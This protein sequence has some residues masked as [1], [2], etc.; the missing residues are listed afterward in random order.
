MALTLSGSPL[1]QIANIQSIW[2]VIKGGS[3]FDP[4]ELRPEKQLTLVGDGSWIVAC[5]C[6]QCAPL[7]CLE[8]A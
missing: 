4:E 7:V 6:G 1:E 3:V 5:V 2:R 8:C